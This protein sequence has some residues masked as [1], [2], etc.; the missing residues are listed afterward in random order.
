LLESLRGGID[1]MS[2]GASAMFSRIPERVK[3]L[4]NQHPRGG[5]ISGDGEF[6]FFRLSQPEPID[7][8]AFVA[9]N[10]EARGNL[11]ASTLSDDASDPTKV[12]DRSWLIP[13]LLCGGGLFIGGTILA[14]SRRRKRETPAAAS[15]PSTQPL[16]TMQVPSRAA[17][18]LTLAAG[19]DAKCQIVTNS[20][21]TYF[22][23]FD[24]QTELGRTEECGFQFSHRQISSHHARVRYSAVDD[25]FYVEDLGSRNGT[26]LVGQTVKTDRALETGCLLQLGQS[27]SLEFQRIDQPNKAPIGILRLS[28]IGDQPNRNYV[29]VP[30][31][32]IHVAQLLNDVDTSFKIYANENDELFVESDQSDHNQPIEKHT[33]TF[34]EHQ[35]ITVIR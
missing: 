2:F 7:F 32:Q 5:T 1:S 13:L 11:P 22:C 15:T 6:Y 24:A 16:A 4:S 27:I 18:Q 10:H 34:F 14:L 3:Q 35:N 23:V 26:F 29:I 21:E 30:S 19:S 12:P 17:P 20:G 25:C 28:R 8:E 31:R 33:S 9:R